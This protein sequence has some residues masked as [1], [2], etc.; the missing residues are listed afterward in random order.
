MP[1]TNSPP[2]TGGLWL[3]STTTKRWT[4]SAKAW[5]CKLTS[6]NRRYKWPTWNRPLAKGGLR[7]PE[8]ID[9][10]ATFDSVRWGLDMSRT[11]SGAICSAKPIKHTAMDVGIHSDRE[12][13]VTGL[14]SHGHLTVL[15][16]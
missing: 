6:L 4:N 10:S 12:G 2:I 15:P 1:L 13:G 11:K 3:R 5:K 8:Q 9:M 16:L 7:Q 14:G